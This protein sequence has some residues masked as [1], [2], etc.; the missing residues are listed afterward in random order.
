[1]KAVQEIGKGAMADSF[2]SIL[3]QPQVR[4][5]LRKSL[6]AGRISHAYLFVGPAGSNKTQTAYALAQA[7]LCSQKE[8][9]TR[10]GMCGKCENCSRIRRKTHPDVRYISPEGA[11][12]YLVE[13]IRDIVADVSY[14]PIQADR[15]IYIIDRVDLLSA[16]AANAF[17]KTLEE[18]PE[19]AVFILLG[20]TKDSVLDTI[21]S[22]CQVI[23]FRHIPPSEAAGII[24]QNT[25][26]PLVQATEA[27]EVCSG[28][29]TAAIGFL[30]S[31][32]NK[33]LAYRQ[34]LLSNLVHIDEMDD[35][36][37]LKFVRDILEKLNVPISDFKQAQEDD[38]KNNADFLSK[39]ALRQIEAR[40]KRQ[41]NAKTA[42]YLRQTLSIMAS[43]LRD[44]MCVAIGS[45]ELVINKDIEGEAI[46]LSSAVSVSDAGEAL[47]SYEEANTLLDYNVTPELVLD[48]AVFKIR[49]AFNG[50]Y[51]TC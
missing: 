39:S 48:V 43:F 23:P 8:G 30:N 16:S 29:I 42:E 3:G 41:V 14:A 12:G 9:V 17:L 15:K 49:E 27:L 47:R 5:F 19:H 45:P 13:Q 21:A 36:G 51:S 31:A 2:E 35:W 37:V 25:G 50:A 20:R 44:V 26:A 34:W 33:N 32:G 40:N 1:M 24:S 7:L 46:R 28:S 22:R 4:G 18:P 38:I 10:G 11:N 6:S